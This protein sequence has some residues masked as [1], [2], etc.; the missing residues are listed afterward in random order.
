VR[1]R[2][3][4]ISDVATLSGTSDDVRLRVVADQGRKYVVVVGMIEVDTERLGCERNGR[5]KKVERERER[6]SE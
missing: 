5:V 2:Y 3:T 6:L 4:Y 1:Y